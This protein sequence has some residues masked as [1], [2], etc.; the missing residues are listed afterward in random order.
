MEATTDCSLI[1]H[2]ESIQD[3]RD[4]RWSKH[5]LMD[6]IFITLCAVIC[7]A[8]G[9]EDIENFAKSHLDWFVQ[10]LKLPH[11][12]P[13]HD[14]F[15]RVFERIRPDQF[16]E[17]FEGWVNTIRE[18]F[19]REVVGVDGKSLRGSYTDSANKS[20]DMLHMVSAWA[21][22][23]SLILGQVKTDEKS[24]EITAIPIL[25]K[26]LFLSGCI[27]TI[28]AIGC[29]RA[30]AKEIKNQGADYILSVKENQASLYNAINKAFSHGDATNFEAMV[31]KQAEQN[32]FAHG[33]IET[34]KCTVLPIMY[35]S[36]FKEKWSGLTSIARIESQRIIKK[37]GEVEKEDTYYISS[38]P[39]DAGL[40]LTSKREHWGVENKIHWLLDVVFKED[41][42][43]IR[44]RNSAQNFSVVRRLAINMIKRETSVK[45]SV[46]QRRMM[47]GWNRK[48]L[49]KILKAN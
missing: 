40:I 39:L 8:E 9:W 12:I 22:K 7:G 20:S 14:T 24:N 2:F 42:S 29:Q 28:D 15:R 21:S 11:G 4:P 33:R 13:H 49:E 5:V 35:L 19:S 43:R 37:T 45:K 6:I 16:E 36:Q 38:L 32:D 25:L 3:Y 17:S 47:A 46:R 26:N 10:F 48:Y 27:V 44:D 30:I 18:N 31:Y 1:D 41:A 23:N 34:R